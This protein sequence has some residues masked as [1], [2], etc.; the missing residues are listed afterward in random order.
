MLWTYLE[1]LEEL[2]YD[3]SENLKIATEKELHDDEISKPLKGL[4]EVFQK[5]R[6]EDDLT[7]ED[8]TCLE[9]FIDG[10]TTVS[11]NPNIVGENV[12]KIVTEV[13]VHHHTKT[14]RK[15]DS[16]CRFNYPRFPTPKT[17]VAKPF[18]GSK[19]DRM[20]RMTDYNEILQKISVVL[21]EKEIVEKIMLSYSKNDE[22][23]S[24]HPKL[25]EE[26]IR[27]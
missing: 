24:E 12:V 6:N 17:I 3:E 1:K 19:E 16:S 13:N 8:L 20:K 5:L 23:K 9:N 21:E 14:C 10:F 11:L 15:Y 2:V 22:T 18:K 7:A 25:I 27:T 26:R 4:K